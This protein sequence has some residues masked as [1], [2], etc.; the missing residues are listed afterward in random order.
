MIEFWD[1]MAEKEEIDIDDEYINRQLRWREIER[2]LCGVK[3]I[4]D[5]GAATGAFSVELAKRGYQVTHLDISSKMIEAAKEKAKGLNT[6]NFVQADAKDLYMYK[7]NSF[8]LVLNLDGAISFSGNGY[9]RVISESC[10]VAKNK[11]L[12]SASNK[13]C[14]TATW[15]NYSMNLHN[16]I[17]PSVMEMIKTGLW[18]K[19]Q[20]EENK[21]I[22][23]C[24]KVDS[25]KAFTPDELK[26]DLEQNGVKVEF[27]RSIGSL[28]HLYLLHLYRQLPG[29]SHSV[30]L[31]RNEDFIDLCERFDIEVMPNGPGSFRR[32]GVIA[33]AKK[34]EKFPHYF[35]PL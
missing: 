33:L 16:C 3:T 29:N 30:T 1:D 4:L 21:K 5:I 12:V 14:M 28:T 25:F 6:I 34:V 7:D 9:G 15:L 24:F 22:S 27:S 2:N 8:D 26:N 20:Y 17:T 23:E 32:A 18:N 31:S 11:L 10:R 35:P 19:D 13:G